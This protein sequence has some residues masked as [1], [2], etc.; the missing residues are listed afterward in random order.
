MLAGLPSP[1]QCENGQIACDDGTKC[2]AETDLCDFFPDCADNSDED[3]CDTALM[4]ADNEFHCV[5]DDICIP[6][7]FR[8]DGHNDCF[9]GADEQSCKL[10]L[11]TNRK[12]HTRCRLAPIL[13]TS[14]DLERPKRP[15]RRNKQ[16][17]RSPTEKNQRK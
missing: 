8:C 4:C 11:R 17:F 5:N 1:L 12:S 10:L 16:K 6:L 15:A 3:N 13:L 9:D 14:D 7:S 2:I